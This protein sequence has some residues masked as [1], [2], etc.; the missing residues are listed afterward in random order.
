M[1]NNKI[2]KWL[3]ILAVI[4]ILGGIALYFL[5]DLILFHPITLKKDH[6]YEFSEKHKDINIPISQNSNLNIVQFLST[7]T[8]TKGVVLYFHGNKKNISWYAQYPPYFTKHG[9][10]VWMIDYP[11]F[12]KSTGKFTE[13]NLYD[14]SDYLYQFA[15]SKISADSIIIYGKSM[16]TG[17]AAHLASVQPCKKLILE[18]PY[19][20][21]PSVIKHYLPF[22]PANWMIHYKIPTHQYIQNVKAPVTIFHGTDDNVIRYSNAEK[23]KPFL[24]PVDEF[25]TIKDG[26]H[27]NLFKFKKTIEKLDSIL[28]N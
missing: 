22:Y 16:G 28:I 7:D 14:W 5:Q 11:G 10:E 15:L 4:Y 20:D 13:Q 2:W 27:N 24:K 23:L 25:I 26:K 19:Y 1:K 12:G 21:F 8:S 6:K 9:F 17:I 18:T 3:K